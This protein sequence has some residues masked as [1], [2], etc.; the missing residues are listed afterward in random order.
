MFHNYSEGEKIVCIDNKKTLYLS[1]DK[2]Y[3]VIYMY[4]E[5]VQIED[6]GGYINGF[7]TERFRSLY[8]RR[9]DIISQ[10]P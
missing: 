9:K 2:I 1:E 5:Y 8:E 6:D 10:L 4:G 7:E 3:R